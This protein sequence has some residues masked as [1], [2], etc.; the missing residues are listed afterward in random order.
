MIRPS[1]PEVCCSHFLLQ[2][3]VPQGLKAIKDGAGGIEARRGGLGECKPLP[4]LPG[5]DPL[6][7]LTRHSRAGLW[8]LP[9]LRDWFGCVMQIGVC[10]LEL[11]LPEWL[12]WT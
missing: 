12:R 6:A 2:K 10:R 9:S 8:S 1:G 7:K 5:L 11:F 4:S 3:T